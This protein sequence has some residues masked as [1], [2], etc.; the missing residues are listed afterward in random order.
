MTLEISE[1][2][3]KARSNFLHY[4]AG[5]SCSIGFVDV[6]PCLSF[7]ANVSL[8]WEDSKCIFDLAKILRL[9][10]ISFLLI[11]L[12][13]TTLILRN[14]TGQLFVGDYRFYCPVFST[15]YQFS[16]TMRL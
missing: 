4:A 11:H 2:G 6:G 10:I 15:S 8:T 3:L 5:K 16:V 9:R 1:I 7:E 12:L 13:P 14:L